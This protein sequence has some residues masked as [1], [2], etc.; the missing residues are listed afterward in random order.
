MIN[1][2]ILRVTYNGV[3][4][5]LDVDGDVPLRLDISQ[6]INQEIGQVYGIASQ[7]FNLPGSAKN[8]KFFNHAYDQAAIDIPG[9][10]NT[11][12][13]S[14]IRNGETL[15]QGQLQLIQVITSEEGFIT[16]E[17]LITDSAV[18]FNA[19]LGD[20]LLKNADFSAYDHTLTS[21]S[22]ISSWTTPI[23]GAVFYPLADY[24]ADEFSTY[25]FEPII[26]LSGNSNASGSI[27]NINT[28][29]AVYQFLPAI[30]VNK[31][32]DAICKQAGFA[33][34]SSFLDSTD[35]DNIYMLPKSKED[36][37]IVGE[38]QENTLQTS[39]S[40]NQ[41]AS[42]TGPQGIPYFTQSFIS[43][44]SEINDPGNNY[45]PTTYEYTAPYDGAYFI[46]ANVILDYDVGFQGSATVAIA[47]NG[48]E[49]DVAQANFVV[50]DG[51][52]PYTGTFN[53][54]LNRRV[55]LTKG[56][57]Y[58]M[59]FE[60]NI[61]D[62]D[63]P[64]SSWDL[65]LTLKSGSTFDI[66]RALSIYDDAPVNMALQ[67]DSEFKSI[68][69]FKG[70]L[71]HFNLVAYVEPGQNKV[72][73]IEQIDD[74]LRAGGQKD[75]TQKY[76][77]AKRIAINHTVDEQPKT[78]LFQQAEDSDRFSKLTQESEPNF[79][80]GTLRTISDSNVTT[81]ETEIGKYFA[82]VVLASAIEYG[83]T[84]FSGV[85]TLNIGDSN[86]VLPHLYKYENNERK[87]FKFKPRIGYR[88]TPQVPSSAT[89]NTIYIGNS[90]SAQAVTGLY[91]TI[92]NINSLPAVPS[93]SKDLHFNS[94]YPSYV[95]DSFKINS[96]S[97][98]YTN[99][100]KTYVDS[101]Y[102]D[103]AKKVTLDLFFEEYEYQD[104]K[105]N[106]KIFIGDNA[107]RINKIKGFN[108][109][110]RDVV[111]VELLKEFPAYFPTVE[112]GDVVCPTVSITDVNA[113]AGGSNWLLTGSVDTTGSD[114]A[115][116]RGFVWLT[117]S[118]T[119]DINNNFVTASGA[120]IGTFY[121]SIPLDG[122]EEYVFRAFASSSNCLVYSTNEEDICY[123]NDDLN[124]F[125]HAPSLITSES[126]VMSGSVTGTDTEYLV[127]RGFVYSTTNFNMFP[128][129]AGA[130]TLPVPPHVV[131]QYSA[132]LSGLDSETTYYYRAYISKSCCG[133]SSEVGTLLSASTLT[134]AACP[135][136]STYPIYN[137]T[138]SSF[139]MSGSVD[140][141]GTNPIV[142][143]GFVYSSTDSTPTIGEP[144][145][146]KQVA[147]LGT[148]PG[149][150]SGSVTGWNDNTN[151]YVRAYASSSGCEE[152][153]DTVSG[154]TLQAFYPVTLEYGSVDC[155]TVCANYG[156]NPSGTFY[157]D[158]GSGGS[159]VFAIS[160]KI[161]TDAAGTTPAPANFY[162]DGTD[163][164]PADGVGNLGTTTGCGP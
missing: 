42:I 14:V 15:L 85:A 103:E 89:N 60:T 37:G 17:V 82:P 12:D 123:G 64:G 7:N 124:V 138:T 125:T 151:I 143:R 121:A 114:G 34:T 6:V 78:L 11:V 106:D 157:V 87:S 70:I 162:T 63:D 47:L 132:S 30:K 2:L 58:K 158:V 26:N 76:N 109:T 163:C 164:R 116:I 32:I 144:G 55:E 136:V 31:V 130:T 20:K 135:E 80:Y 25:P 104:I 22:I 148:N 134:N 1:D 95:P 131:G 88:V 54:G 105:L 5:D 39:M 4:T 35:F 72:I 74:W 56:N 18:E 73:K 67:F 91:G 122:C 119:P 137:I 97:N 28:P 40:A 127:E 84:N 117:G 129:D 61:T 59:Q 107:Y 150:F 90:G 13:C 110:R 128:G 38:V 53:M 16:Y 68:D 52:P 145:V 9:F 19:A 161:Y 99:Y 29:M 147:P 149:H 10:Y 154:S 65:T 48:P 100:W 43:F 46:D 62:H 92:S 141:V 3:V 160:T 83:G 69:V 23:S 142:E 101:L 36:L 66:P 133:D 57:T 94:T 77:T 75:W 159:G 45:N 108:L 113:D 50:A 24:G 8:N 33:Y 51:N 146:L 93:V 152:Y 41:D 140:S 126:F 155:A 120:G 98:N 156:S 21:G 96:G 81:G 102:W 153:G 111:T 49:G 115:P 27:D 112:A 139:G 44:D 86:L 79:Q 71:E 118:G